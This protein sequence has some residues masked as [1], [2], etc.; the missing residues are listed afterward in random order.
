[1][2]GGLLGSVA[3]LATNFVFLIALLLFL[4]VES[5]GVPERMA[6]IG[7]D[8]PTVVEALAKFAYGTRQYLLVTTVFGFI[9][10]VLDTIAL[11]I[12]G[13]P[14]AITWGVLAFVTNYIPNVG[15]ILGVIPPAL[16]GRLFVANRVVP[17]E[18]RN[19][20]VGAV[21]QARLARRRRGGR[22]GPPARPDPGTGPRRHR[23][24]AGDRVGPGEAGYRQVSGVTV[25]WLPT[26]GG[27]PRA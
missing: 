25:V 7:A 26:A 22:P 8:R 6:E 24:G 12:M 18:G 13:I 27:E 5:S 23:P 17:A 1:M 16:L 21:Q 10:A 3:G 9:V 11:A 20:L 19:A 15:F 4:S 14:L 2:I